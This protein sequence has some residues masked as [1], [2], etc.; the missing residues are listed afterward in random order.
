MSITIDQESRQRTR[1]AI[2]VNFS[3]NRYKTTNG[4]YTFPALELEVFDKY[5]YYLLKYSVQKRFERQYI[6]KPDYM[7][8]D[9][10]GTVSLAQML[11]YINGVP[12]IEM[13][14]LDE[15][16]VPSYSAVVEILKDKFAV[17]DPDDLFEVDR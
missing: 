5:L 10:Y 7:S 3:G 8:F 6:M 16:V 2:D 14:D 17:Q 15:V 9:E 4:L 13:F 12:S 1:L 11:M